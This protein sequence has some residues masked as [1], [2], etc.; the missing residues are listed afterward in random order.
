MA[1]NNHND[2]H[3]EI[4]NIGRDHPILPF[5]QNPKPYNDT[6]GSSRPSRESTSSEKS[7]KPTFHRQHSWSNQDQKHQ[8]QER[9][10]RSEKGKE[11]GFTEVH[12]GD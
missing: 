8:L 9:L 1:S 2:N 6:A 5:A 4:P 11:T 12:S 7:W 3:G 10:Y